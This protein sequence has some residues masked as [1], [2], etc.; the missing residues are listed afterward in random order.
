MS[1]IADN[2]F[3]IQPGK[4]SLADLRQIYRGEHMVKLDDTAYPVIQRSREVVENIIA[5]GRTA[6]GINT[7]FGLLRY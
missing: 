1:A 3:T 5:E 7:G 6:Y 4:M 2:I